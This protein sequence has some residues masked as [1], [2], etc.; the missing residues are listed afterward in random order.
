M[1]VIIKVII[2][3]C[4]V[5]LFGKNIP[6][7]KN[8]DYK[9]FNPN[10]STIND[11]AENGHYVWCALKS[12]VLRIDKRDNS[13]VR[14]TVKD[15]LS[16]NYVNKIFAASNG[17][18]WCLTIQGI[19][20]FDGKNWTAYCTEQPLCI[21]AARNMIEDSSG[22]MWFGSDFGF[23]MFDGEKWHEY[24]APDTLPGNRTFWIIDDSK[25]I[26]WIGT[27]KGIVSFNGAEWQQYRK[28]SLSTREGTNTLFEDSS[29]RIWFGSLSGATVYENGVFTTHHREADMPMNDV[30]EINEDAYGVLWFKSLSGLFSLKDGKWKWQKTSWGD[31]HFMDKQNLLWKALD[32]AALCISDTTIAIEYPANQRPDTFFFDNTNR[33]WSQEPGRKGSLARYDQTGW[34]IFRTYSVIDDILVGRA[35]VDSENNVWF[36]SKRGEIAKIHNDTV[37]EIY[38]GV[39]PEIIMANIIM[40]HNDGSVWFSSGLKGDMSLSVFR[41]DNWTVHRMPPTDRINSVNKLFTDR[42]GRIIACMSGSYGVHDNDRWEFHDIEISG[43]LEY[44]ILCGIE[45]SR[46]QLWF[47]MSNSA[48][49]LVKDDD[50]TILYPGTRSTKTIFEDSNGNIWTGGHGGVARFDG[51]S[52]T[53]Y[54]AGGSLLPGKPDASINAIVEDGKETLW[55]A[56]DK[57]VVKYNEDTWTSISPRHYNDIE[58]NATS[59]AVDIQDNVWFG[60]EG[61]G[62]LF[63]DRSASN[64]STVHDGRIPA[65]I[66]NIAVDSN[67]S[68]WIGTH[69]GVS[70]YYDEVGVVVTHDLA[71]PST[72]CLL[73]NYPNPFNPSTTIEYNIPEASNVNLAIYSLSGQKVSMLVDAFQES[74]RHCVVFDGQSLASGIYFYKLH[75]GT[76]KQSGKMLLMK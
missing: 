30:Y 14:Y 63:Y 50:I 54:P 71:A 21:Y 1:K 11:Y 26:L 53:Q 8:L 57:G 23:A 24:Y 18:V 28:N 32:T 20:R 46:G 37:T 72:T 68:I 16:N 66:G 67:G 49:A 3:I 22:R 5:S 2:L 48:C 59:A 10:F 64:L 9:I 41:N 69:L 70:V 58:A 25:N 7:Q 27:D 51:N 55:F 42:S 6:A 43:E 60:T 56:T 74:G 40:P 36:Q 31:K 62:L 47:G 35:F 17:N 45:D 29:G 52:W 4:L 73:N 76:R 65:A 75:S 44:E 12:G 15:G 38:Y 34:K 39:G 33:L 13:F 61:Q 19:C